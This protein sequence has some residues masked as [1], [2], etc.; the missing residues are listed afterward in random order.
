MKNLKA[1]IYKGDLTPYQRALAQREFEGMV[2]RLEIYEKAVKNEIMINKIKGL[3]KYTDCSMP[4]NE[5]GRIDKAEVSAYNQAIEDVVKL[6]AIPD[7][8][9]RSEQS[10][11]SCGNR[12]VKY[13]FHKNHGNKRPVSE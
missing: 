12:L 10:V 6:F 2:E 7:V 4:S 1:L 8:V 3:R 5:A 9:G 11:C 13:Q